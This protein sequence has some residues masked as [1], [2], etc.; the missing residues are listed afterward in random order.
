MTANITTLALNL[1]ISERMSQRSFFASK[2]VEMLND[3]NE[4]SEKE[5]QIK[6]D[7]KSVIEQCVQDPAGKFRDVFFHYAQ[8]YSG[9]LGHDAL[10]S[11]A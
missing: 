3:V 11:A 4:N 5:K 2:I 10:H 8:Y 6:Q 7:F 1:L 9:V